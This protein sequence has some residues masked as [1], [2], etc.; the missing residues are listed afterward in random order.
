MIDKIV[1]IEASSIRYK[2]I[3]AIP[4]IHS[5]AYFA[6]A[7]REAVESFKPTIVV[8]EHPKNYELLLREAITR[9]PYISLIIK[10][11]RSRNAI[12]VPIDP[13]DSMIEAVACAISKEID[14]AAIDL[15]VDVFPSNSKYLMPDD[16]ALSKVGLTTFYEYVLK[17]Y[18]FYKDDNKESIDIKREKH[19]A[20][21]LAAISKTHERVLFVCGLSHWEG[22]KSDLEKYLDA[23]TSDT[24][25]VES[26][27]EKLKTKKSQ[28]KSKYNI[29]TVHK[30]SLVHVLGEMPF[31]TY[32]YEMYKSKELD[33][34]SKIKTIEIAYT[35]ARH[36][37]KN[38]I[39]F[40]Q[41]KRLG[42]YARNLAIVDGNIVP[43]RIDVLTAAKCMVNN[44]YALEVLDV[45]D[46]YPY[47]S[48]EDN[49]YPVI[50]IDR[51]PSSAALTTFLKNKKV[52]L[53]RH[54]YVWKT[55]LKKS[56][57]TTRPNEAYD[58]EWEDMWDRR[59]N[60]LSHVPEDISMERYMNIIRERTTL[61]LTEDKI[62]I[63]PFTVSMK[64]GIDMRETIK[65]YHEKKVYVKEIP[66]LKGNIG[67]VV[68]I[69][70]EEHDDYYTCRMVWYSEAHDD[71]DLVMYS[72]APGIELIGPG[73][74]KSYFGGYASLMPPMITEEI[75]VEYSSLKKSGIIKNC[76]DFLLFMAI[77]FSI[78]KYLVY[79]APS[80]PSAI[81]Y[82][83]AKKR[84]VEIIYIPLSTLANETIN[85][86]KQFHILG[87]KR[88]R[89][90]ANRYII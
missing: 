77:E 25:E 8:V 44:D 27:D 38:Q 70:D 79:T 17:N 23:N 33:Y 80:K 37:Y 87:D 42:D 57:V 32:F 7:V 89:D 46:Y 84:N 54:D 20:K 14:F 85:K 28:D 66:K 15:D 90:I 65:N 72:T 13:C 51:D 53:K 3:L 12:F 63:E 67:H 30:N 82:D 4:S 11:S 45:I 76:A 48:D 39:S 49:K 29:Y 21:K 81:L 31:V 35:E 60:M 73:I 18:D 64:D 24:P 26:S 74:S 68:M 78:D 47:Y 43:D 41:Q 88:L 1:D 69:F 9:L 61:M 40:I 75:W 36:K 10:T 6:M 22:I 86:L 59:N 62:K 5:R 52:N 2:N 58:G 55:S 16:Y 83:E 50:E 19:M 34:F 71:S 56:S